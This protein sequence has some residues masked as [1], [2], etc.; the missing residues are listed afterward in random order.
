M[1]SPVAGRRILLRIAPETKRRNEVTKKVTKEIGAE[2]S[3]T[4]NSQ[5]K[6][7]MAAILPF[8]KVAATFETKHLFLLYQCAPSVRMRIE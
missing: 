6:E 8:R 1:I 4:K 2:V 5:R 3:G 7:K